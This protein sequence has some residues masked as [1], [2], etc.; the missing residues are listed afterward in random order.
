MLSFDIRSLETRAAIVDEQLP[1]T[2]PVWHEEDPKPDTA[3]HVTGRLSSA[4][5]GRFY[6]HGRIEGD[7]A[8]ECRRCLTPTRVHVKD[9]THVIFADRGDENTED[10]DVFELDP[11]ASELDLRPAIRE[12]WLLSAPTLALCRDDCKG[13]CLRCGEDLNAGP[14]ECGQA[15]SDPRWATLRKVN[16]TSK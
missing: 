1:A 9:E 16:E 7:V 15:E 6:W 10:P 12:E 2:D 8:L 13:L 5:P 11:H 4:G 14:H 3:V